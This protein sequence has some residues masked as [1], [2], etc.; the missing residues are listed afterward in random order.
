MHI[1]FV[2]GGV[3]DVFQEIDM[4]IPISD[5]DIVKGLN[6]GRFHTSINE[7][8]VYDMDSLEPIGRIIS[9]DFSHELDYSNFELVE[10][11]S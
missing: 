6:S 10:N 1:K 5:E 3:A 11:N 2:V 8:R 7:N 9:T 4:F